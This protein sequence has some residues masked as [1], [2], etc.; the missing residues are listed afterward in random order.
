VTTTDLYSL[1]PLIIIA[2]ASIVV[3]IFIAIKRNHNIANTF[4]LLAFAFALISLLNVSHLTP[5]NISVLF[6]VDNYS[7]LFIGLILAAGFLVTMLCYKYLDQMEENKEEFY[8]LILIASLG[9]SVLVISNHFISFFLGLEVLS[10]PLYVLI[11]YLRINQRALEAGIKYLILAATSSAFLLFGM[12]L[13][14]SQTGTMEFSQLALR[15]SPLGLNTPILFSGFA[16]MII[17]VGFKLAVVPFHLWTPDVYEGAPAPVTAFIATVSKGGMFALLIRFFHELNLYQF[18]SL[19]LVFS[20][21]AIASMFFGNLLALMQDNVKRILAYSSIAHFGYLLVAF[22][23]SGKLG[24]E[25][26][27]FYIAAYFITTLGAFGIITIF[28]NKEREADDIE[29][30][31]GL[32]WRRPLIATVFTAMLFSLAGIPLTAGF[33]GKYYVLLSGVGSS[34][35]L[36]V[37]ILVVNS[38]IGLYYYLRIVVKMF[39]P[40]DESQNEFELPVPSFSLGGVVALFILLVFLIWFG[41]YPTGLLAVIKLM[42]SGLA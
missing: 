16:M 10:V 31:K 36:L 38:V 32:F 4:A 42:V 28:S 12:A 25:A 37:V 26:A 24:V 29:D 35:W 33:I 9:S 15:I 19:I 30:Y 6:I 39:A 40:S 13:V 2:G 22:L 17:G 41:V 1:M 11:S 18:D 5:H 23:A 8:I 34:L 20:I 27:T 7:L 21:I 14:Y 3:M